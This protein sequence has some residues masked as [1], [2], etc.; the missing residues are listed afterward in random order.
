M[1]KKIPKRLK[2]E[3]LLE[4][5]WEIRFSSNKGT[6]VEILPGMIYQAFHGDFQKI[7]RLPAA[8]LPSQILQ[9]DVNLRYVPT[10]KLEGSP[11]TIQI[12]E[13]VVSISC[14]RPYAGW[15]QFKSKI[16]D[17]SEKLKQT[18]LITQPERFSL[19]Y[20]DIIPATAQPSLEPLDIKI[21]L[22]T[23][24]IDRNQ[25][26]LR[27]EIIEEYLINVIQIVTG[28]H[29]STPTGEQFEGI[30]CDIDTIY[31]GKDGDFWEDFSNNLD[32]AHDSNKRQFFYL[33]KNDTIKRLEPEY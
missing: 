23:R 9:Q 33:L 10:V 27:T 22:G 1:N 16:L 20:I 32:K 5:L 18:A 31:Q 24:S 6:V 17:L 3:P 11:Y 29:A 15:E 25:V 12:G 4:A 28:A 2:K 14:P 21:Q 26:Q 13:H 19:K 30:L 7:E 8:N